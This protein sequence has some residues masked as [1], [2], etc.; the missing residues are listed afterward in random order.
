[1][2]RTPTHRK[3][4]AQTARRY[5]EEPNGRVLSRHGHPAVGREG[6]GERAALFSRLKAADRFP[7]RGLPE[8]NGAVV[9]RVGENFAV[10]RK[11]GREVSVMLP[12]VEWSWFRATT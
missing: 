1:M 7:C 4:A 2:A 12:A 11:G 9:A 3:L 6:Q 5:L 10:G 8:V